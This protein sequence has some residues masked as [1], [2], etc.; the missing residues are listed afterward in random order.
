METISKMIDGIHVQHMG[1]SGI[2]FSRENWGRNIGLFSQQ[3]SQKECQ[4]A[5]VKQNLVINHGKKW[6][7]V[8]FLCFFCQILYF[9]SQQGQGSGEIFFLVKQ[10]V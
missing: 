1:F 3:V 8:P 10:Q 6:K 9:F 4:N 5:K 2:F 7:E